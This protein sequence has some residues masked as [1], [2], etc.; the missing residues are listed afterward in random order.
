MWRQTLLVS[1]GVLLGLV[2]VGVVYELCKNKKSQKRLEE[3]IDNQAHVEML[4]VKE[5]SKWFKE[6]RHQFSNN[7]KMVVTYPTEDILKGLGYESEVYIDKETN[8]I[9]FFYDEATS[10]AMKIRLINYTEIDSNLQAQ[11]LEQDGM[12]VVTD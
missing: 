3:L 7:A 6:N 9:Q 11:L 5:L 2:V 10:R 8:I 1:G 12:L 4:T